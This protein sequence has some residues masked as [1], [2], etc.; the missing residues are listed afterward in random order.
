[1]VRWSL[2]SEFFSLFILA[3]LFLR[4]YCYEWR[5]AFTGM[6]KLY[7]VCLGASAASILLDICGALTISYSPRIPLWLNI[8]VNSCYFFVT[9]VTC[10][11]FAYLL[12]CLVLEHVYDKRCL[13][14]AVRVLVVL[15]AFYILLVAANLF[16]GLLFYFDESGFYQ[17]GPLNRLVYA[18]PLT[19]L[20]LLI[21]CYFRN[22]SSAGKPL[23]HVMRSL[24][25]IVL[26]LSLFQLAYPEAL[27]NGMLC[28]MASLIIFLC[29]Q[30]HINDRDGLTGIRSRGNFLTELSLRIAGCQPLHI[31]TVSLLTFSDVNFQYGHTVGD[32][33]LYEV[34]QSLDRLFP[35]GRAFRI[36]S[37]T[38]A[39][40]L[41]WTSQKRADS[42]L[43]IVQQRFRAPWVLGD[44]RC[45]LSF[46]MAD[47]R[48]DG[49]E[50]ADQ[51]MEQLEYT[52]SLAKEER[53][54]I[55]FDKEVRRRLE[56]KQ[57]MIAIMRRSIQERRFRVWYQPLYCCQERTFRSAEA[58]LR[59]SDYSGAP[60]SPNV[61]IPL[62]EETGMI[63]ELT[64]IV[65]EEVCRLL[66]S[67]QAPGL[68]A[69]SLNLSMQQLLDPHLADRIQRYL[70]EYHLTPDR[71]K[72]EITERFL[73]HDAR[74]AKRQLESLTSIGVELLMDDFGTGYSNLS[75]VLNFP[76]SCIKFDRSL[77]QQI[78]EDPQAVQ[79]LRTLTGL[80]H[81]MEKI[82]VMEGVETAAQSAC[83]LEAGADMIQ[84][85]Y[86]AHPM[87]VEELVACFAAQQTEKN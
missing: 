47:L 42:C 81:D 14:R 29:F 80:F 15:T 12:F 4:Y 83:A 19:E 66:S 5:V 82:L 52:L 40:T 36:S 25:P 9:V 43:E 65:L 21:I 23:I 58:L 1:M 60:V 7:L 30:S 76:F 22:R 62:A 75:S 87:P 41:P 51:V 34:A 79:M 31:I 72:V 69:V 50:A 28:A 74:Y 53:A 13:K 73:L 8:L 2:L 71:L 57:A 35:Q 86:Y 55:R 64:W 27:L 56:E 85:F 3:V 10:S 16:T 24:P 78:P 46:C 70:T 44:I 84:G 49:Q 39:L 45:Q 77:I 68:Q 59:L 63:G 20:F 17:R 18:L 37:L 54:V 26:L 6:R 11:L 38:F 33:V 48:C 32:A 67:G 61:F